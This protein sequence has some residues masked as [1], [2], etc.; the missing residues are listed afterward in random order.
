M[1]LIIIKHY[2]SLVF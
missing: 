1:S 2:L